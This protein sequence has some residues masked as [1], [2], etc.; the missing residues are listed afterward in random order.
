[1]TVNACKNISETAG[2][3]IELI[4]GKASI[5]LT[6]DGNIVLKGISIKNIADTDYAVETKTL[7]SDG[8]IEHVLTG[9]IVKINP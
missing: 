6:K 5:T 4:C 1:M 9:A 8:S 3:K 2:E 7:T